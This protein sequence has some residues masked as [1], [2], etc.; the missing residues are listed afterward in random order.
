MAW[1]EY[2]N[3]VLQVGDLR[4]EAVEV[5]RLVVVPGP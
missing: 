1:N 5:F 2:P 3:L 4:R